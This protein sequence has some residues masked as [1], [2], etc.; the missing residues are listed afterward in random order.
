MASVLQL[1]GK[2]YYPR[3]PDHTFV[4]GS[5]SVY[6][7]LRN[8]QCLNDLRVRIYDFFFTTWLYLIHLS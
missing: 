2:A 6:Q 3:A 8:C 4:L 7:I 5:M 1:A